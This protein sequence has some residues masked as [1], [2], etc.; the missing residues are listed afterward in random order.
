M[1]FFDLLIGGRYDKLCMSMIKQN[2]TEDRIKE[3]QEPS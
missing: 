2:N 3:N 1:M